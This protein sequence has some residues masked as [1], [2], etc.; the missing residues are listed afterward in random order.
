M[1]SDIDIS[2]MMFSLKL[3]PRIDG[4][5]PGEMELK[6]GSAAVFVGA[7]GAGKTRLAGWLD[8]Q[9]GNRSTFIHARRSIDMPRRYNIEGEKEQLAAIYAGH[10]A[11]NWNEIQEMK[12]WRY[13]SNHNP[14]ASNDFSNVMNILGTRDSS[15]SRQFRVAFNASPNALPKELRTELDAAL[16]I[17]ENCLPHLSIDASNTPELI[18]KR[19]DNPGDP[20]DPSDMSD[21]ERAIFY[22]VAKCLIAPKNSIIIVDEPEMYVH[23]SIR[24]QLWDA[25]EQERRDCAILYCT[26]DIDFAANRH[27][28]VRYVLIKCNP[29]K[30][31]DRTLNLWDY[32][33]I[34]QDQDIPE[35]VLL[36]V[37]GSRQRVLFIE[38]DASSL[39]R[40]I[41]AARYP[42][43]QLRFLGGCEDV[44]RVVR[45]LSK[46][47][48]V[49]RKQPCGLIDV[50]F[51]TQQE[52]D[53]LQ[54]DFVF[55]HKM[56]E[57][58]NILVS[59]KV[60]EAALENLGKGSE[61][62]DRLTGIHETT[63]KRVK[64]KMKKIAHKMT[65]RELRVQAF[66]IVDRMQRDI[67]GATLVVWPDAQ[68]IE[69]ICLEKV[70]TAWDNDDWD[71]FLSLFSAKKDDFRD[72]PAR[73]MGFNS[74]R[75]AEETL[76]GWIAD[77][78]SENSKRTRDAIA[79][80][81][82]DIS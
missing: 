49:H 25:I 59:T 4:A 76:L 9:L 77:A 3:P 82:P 11:S 27:F 12:E 51:R 26:H 21:G 20:Y 66:D 5:E 65:L 18:V 69:R 6:S 70:N 45:A 58:E 15:A 40:K 14:Y 28:S 10:K 39:D 41:A 34:E 32:A 73:Y 13:S 2:S 31:R 33:R 55:S 60:I 72:I 79:H 37:L 67:H 38:G 30:G 1:A 17:W 35:D 64:S 16:E 61:I 63:K 80:Y 44:I 52:C 57:I 24:N 81:L 50:D 8:K 53:A 56:R 78:E 36:N 22:L 23:A 29:Q 75:E 7:N 71:S 46:A 74:W 48:Q 62:M 43:M 42:K 68:M 47:P 54:L 19:L